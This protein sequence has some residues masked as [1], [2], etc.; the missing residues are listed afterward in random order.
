MQN[1]AVTSDWQQ[2]QVSREPQR[3]QG[4]HFRGA[5]LGRNFLEFLINDAFW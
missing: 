1:S 4:K 2:N 5:P 3:G